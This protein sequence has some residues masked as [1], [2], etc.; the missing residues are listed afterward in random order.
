MN[1]QK[2]FN[3]DKVVQEVEAIREENGCTYIEACIEW[4]ELHGYDVSVVGQLVRRQLKG[5]IQAE[6][7]DLH[8]FKPQAKLPL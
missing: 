7:E 6:A 3:K 1:L 5:K 8:Y 4:S 2:L